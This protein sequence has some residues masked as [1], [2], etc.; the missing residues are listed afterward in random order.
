MKTKILILLVLIIL[1]VVGYF[2][3]FKNNGPFCWPYC[4][5][6]TD[7]D[8]EEIKKQANEAQ[9]EPTVE[10]SE[11]SELKN[12][13]SLPYQEIFYFN[14]NKEKV[15]LCKVK[16]LLGNEEAADDCINVAITNNDVEICENLIGESKFYGTNKDEC[17]FQMA[18]RN[19]NYLICENIVDTKKTYE[20]CYGRVGES[21]FNLSLCEKAGQYKDMCKIAYYADFVS[22]PENKD[23]VLGGIYYIIDE[24]NIF[25]LDNY[26]PGVFNESR[27]FQADSNTFQIIDDK[28]LYT[29]DK[30][31]VYYLGKILKGSNPETFKK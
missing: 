29:K 28:G 13:N 27:I 1:L 3:F 2:T 9:K 26:A 14:E 8:R 11:N 7:E 24:N 10:Q 5:N 19:S 22:N 4:P 25:V 16:G 17:Y 31:N 21:T 23:E 12:N 20:E 30:N 15:N 18:T 6:M